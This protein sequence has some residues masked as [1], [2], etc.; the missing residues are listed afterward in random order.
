MVSPE[1]KK[2][3]RHVYVAVFDKGTTV[4]E[5]HYLSVPEVPL[6]VPDL[7]PVFYLFVTAVPLPVTDIATHLSRDLP[8]R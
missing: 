4:T 7:S 5:P 3:S 6:S 1:G 8:C 2:V